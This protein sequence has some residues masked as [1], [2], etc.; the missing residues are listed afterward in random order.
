MRDTTSA[1]WYLAQQD[2]VVIAELIEFTHSTQMFRWTTSN[3]KIVSSGYTYIPFAGGTGGGIEESIDLGISTIDFVVINSGNELDPII[4]AN[5]L[6]MALMTVRRVHVSTPDGGSIEIY[7]GKV[8]DYGVTRQQISGQARNFFNSINIQWP[9]YT[10]MDQ[11]AWRF[12]GAG[13]GINTTS[14]TVVSTASPV[15]SGYRL[16]ANCAINSISNGYYNKGRFTFT[17]GANSG[18]ARSVRNHTAAGLIE[19]SHAYPYNI[20]SGDTFSLYPGCSKRLIDD[21]TSKYNN[22]R[23][24]L[25]F[26]WIPKQENA[27]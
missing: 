19:F 1:F 4:Q 14:Y 2:T 13:C 22:V 9:P 7:R 16:G 23:N 15:S 6:D 24:A 12:G 8:G 27:F 11:C 21:C 25:A 18:T 5:E 26:P 20:S 3:D 10:Y 17:S